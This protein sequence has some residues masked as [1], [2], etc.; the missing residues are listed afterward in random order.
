MILGATSQETEGKKGCSADDRGKASSLL[1]STNLNSQP[2]QQ[3]TEIRRF[4]VYF[5]LCNSF[6]NL[7]QVILS[8]SAS[9][10]HAGRRHAWCYLPLQRTSL[11]ISLKCVIKVQ[12]Y[13]LHPEKAFPVAITNGEKRSVIQGGWP[14]STSLV[15]ARRVAS[16]KAAAQICPLHAMPLRGTEGFSCQGC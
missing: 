14:L 5:W 10:S 2:C 11:H 6:F 12:H 13:L 16:W 3:R 15:S 9:V 1:S 8:L 7:K 4:W